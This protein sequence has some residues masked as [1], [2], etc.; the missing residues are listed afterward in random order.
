MGRNW[1]MKLTAELTR[2]ADRELVR[3]QKALDDLQVQLNT[4]IMATPTSERRNL[5]TEI[6]MNLMMQK[7]LLDKAMGTRIQ[8]GG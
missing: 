8:E 4:A 1:G 7:E 2:A 6:N 3:T 5:L